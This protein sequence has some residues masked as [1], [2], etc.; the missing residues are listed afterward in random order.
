MPDFHK[1]WQSVIRY[2]IMP[3][4]EEYWIDDPKMVQQFR[5]TLT[6]SVP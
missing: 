6:E 3:L 4:L 1:W 5:V 2:E